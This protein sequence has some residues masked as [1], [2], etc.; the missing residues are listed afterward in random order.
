VY[1]RGREERE[2]NSFGGRFSGD[3]VEIEE[4]FEVT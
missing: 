2:K 4:T 3:L 1:E